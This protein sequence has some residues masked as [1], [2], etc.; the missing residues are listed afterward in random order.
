MT[1]TIERESQQRFR[2]QVQADADPTAN[3]I[4]FAFSF[5]EGVIARPDVWYPG[6]WEIATLTEAGGV[7]T[8][9]SRTPIVGVS[10][11]DLDLGYYQ[12]WARFVSG[13]D[14]PVVKVERLRVV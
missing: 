14:Q 2:V 1:K 4:E 9:F 10:P 13:V 12:V 11:I 7:W 3:P 6:D 5:I 8:V